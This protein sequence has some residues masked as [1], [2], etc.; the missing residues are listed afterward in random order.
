MAQAPDQGHVKTR[1]ELEDTNIDI[2]T[3]I[4]EPVVQIS[5]KQGQI[6]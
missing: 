3:P 2:L 4:Y 1:A 6:D 5:T